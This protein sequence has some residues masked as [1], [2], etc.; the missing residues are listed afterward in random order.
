MS[1]LPPAIGRERFPRQSFGALHSQIKQARVLLIGAGGIGCELLK[2]LV[3]TGFGEIHI[4]D[5][6][7]IDLSN[8]NRQFLFRHEHIKKP[9]ALVSASE[10]GGRPKLNRYKVARDVASTFNPG[11]KLEA[12][13]ADVRHSRFNVEWFQQFRLVFNALDNLA[14]RRHVNKMCLAADIVLIESGTTG[15]DGQVQPIKKGMTACYDCSE[16]EVPKTYPV[17]TIRSTPS[18]PIHCIVWAKSY[19]LPELFGVSEDQE[20]IFD[21]SEDS[22]NKQEIENLKREAQALKS[23]RESMTSDSFPLN[24]FNKVFKDDI[25][26]LK[27]MEDMWKSRKPPQAL[28]YKDLQAQ[29]S[30]IETTIPANDQKVWQVVENFA[31][32]KDSLRRLSERFQLLKATAVD[33]SSMSIITFDKDDNDTLDFV[34]AGANLRSAVFGIESKSKFDVKEMAGNIIPAIATTNAM[35]AA[36]CV[37][38]AMKLMREEYARAKML[39]LSQSEART[40]NSEMLSPPN[41]NCGVCNVASSRLLVDMKRATLNDLVDGILR[42][43]LNY[44]EEI[45]VSNEVG[46]LYDPDLEDNLDKKLSDLGIQDES[47]LTITD[48]ADE[49]PRVNLQFSISSS[50]S[51]T[52]DLKAIT[53]PQKPEIPL[54]PTKPSEVGANGASNG[55]HEESEIDRKRKREPENASSGDDHRVK[56]GKADMVPRSANGAVVLD[57]EGTE[58]AIV[59]D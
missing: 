49:N 55:V 32:F 54:R 18:Q 6:D 50:K 5:L 38:Q 23:I 17:C 58:G 12:H 47:F 16:K 36:L 52:D 4:I 48:E 30:A 39:F 19:L 7:T 40:I 41:P 29:A 42:S 9:K 57:D 28:D 21:H 20:A 14:A 45:S 2:N 22:E 51:L 35:T 46:I 31:V 26:R 13:H 44:G 34:T 33:D 43:Q 1:T 3:T 27:S 10:D 24:V 15:F 37:F 25:E 8:L 53:L 59:L 11:V 56:R